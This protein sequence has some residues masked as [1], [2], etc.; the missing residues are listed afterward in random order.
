[1][2]WHVQGLSS[3]KV[4][5]SPHTLVSSYKFSS[6]QQ[7]ALLLQA[8]DIHTS[9]TCW[10]PFV[11]FIY[12]GN[13]WPP[14][15]DVWDW[16]PAVAHPPQYTRGAFRWRPLLTPS[17]TFHTGGDFGCLGGGQR[18]GNAVII[19]PVNTHTGADTHAQGLSVCFLVTCWSKMQ[20]LPLSA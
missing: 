9:C 20:S 2:K 11:R 17:P 8:V 19:G 3:F 13:L 15:V 4:P 7:S 5:L 10:H 6:L 16:H 1:M 18:E 12:L 14:A